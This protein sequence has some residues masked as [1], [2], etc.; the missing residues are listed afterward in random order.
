MMFTSVY[1]NYDTYSRMQ[2]K[3]PTYAIQYSI[4]S[5]EIMGPYYASDGGGLE[6]AL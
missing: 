5:P 4:Y 3:W 1:M 2:F 6:L